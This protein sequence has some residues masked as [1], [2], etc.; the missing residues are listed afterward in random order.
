MS[1]LLGQLCISHCPL[2]SRLLPSPWR[3]RPLSH[4]ACL[5]HLT[6]RATPSQQPKKQKEKKKRSDA[7]VS[8]LL[9]LSRVSSSTN[10]PL[11]SPHSKLTSTLHQFLRFAPSP[12]TYPTLKKL[13]TS[14]HHSAT[15]THPIPNPEKSTKTFLS[16]AIPNTQQK[17]RLIMV[18]M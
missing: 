1:R 10:A 18:L 8:F 3:S 7:P 5:P 2:R 6:A 12:R 13:K 15:P 16:F 11:S 14:Q 17:V 4:P 9:G